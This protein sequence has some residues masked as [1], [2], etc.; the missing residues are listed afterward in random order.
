MTPTP[1]SLDKDQEEFVRLLAK[2]ER[3][4]STYILTLVP[5][6]ADADEI[7]QETHVRLWQERERY[8]PGTNFTAWALRVA[9]Y[10]VLSHRTR[11]K[12]RP[13]A[14]DDKLVAQLSEEL[15]GLDDVVEARQRAL[16]ECLGGLSERGRSLLRRVYAN[17]EKT[18]DIAASLER[19]TDSLYKTVQRLR[20]SLR[21]CIEQRLSEEQA[22]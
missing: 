2:S 9:Y 21:V 20:H 4:L 12:R 5:H 14:F 22:R 11:A 17:G 15:S 10:E 1:M 3:R 8:E 6:Y 13:M 16:S 7:L 19:T 18:K